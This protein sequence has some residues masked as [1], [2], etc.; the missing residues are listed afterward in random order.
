MP[1]LLAKNDKIRKEM[2][3]RQ[4]DTSFTYIFMKSPQEE[5]EHTFSPNNKLE[6]VADAQYINLMST[7]AYVNS[8]RHLKEKYITPEL[9]DFYGTNPQITGNIGYYDIYQAHGGDYNPKYGRL[10]NNFAGVEVHFVDGFDFDELLKNN[11]SATFLKEMYD[12]AGK[13]LNS[14]N[15]KTSVIYTPTKNIYNEGN[16][17]ERAVNPYVNFQQNNNVGVGTI[18]TE[19][20]DWK[21]TID[22][23]AS[24]FDDV[25]YQEEVNAPNIPTE[26]KYTNDNDLLSKTKELFRTGHIN[27]MIN[28]TQVTVNG[29]TYHKGRNFG[30]DDYGRAWTK[31]NEFLQVKNLTG[32]LKKKNGTGETVMTITEVQNEINKSFRPILYTENNKSYN[33]ADYLADNT[34]LNNSGFVNI[35]PSSVDSSKYSIKRCMF[36]IENLAWKDVAKV[37]NNL[38]EEQRGPNGGRIMWFPPY[39]LDFSENVSVD[40]DPNK[41]IGR[42]EEIFTYTNTRR[43]G[44]LSFSLLIDHPNIINV[45]GVR[46]EAE[47]ADFLKFFAGEGTLETSKQEED[48]KEDTHVPNIV[49]EETITEHEED[50][51]IAFSIYFPYNYSGMYSIRNKETY[52]NPSLNSNDVSDNDWFLYLLLGR[53]NGIKDWDGHSTIDTYW[54]GYEMTSGKGLTY[55]PAPDESD[56]PRIYIPNVM[57]EKGCT[58]EPWQV[59][60]EIDIDNDLYYCRSDFDIR[61]QLGQRRLARNSFDAYQCYKDDDSEQLNSFVEEENENTYPFASVLVA[62]LSANTYNDYVNVYLNYLQGSTIGIA[63]AP[64]QVSELIQKCFF[65]FFR[66]N[67]TKIEITPHV[68]AFEGVNEKN[69]SCQVANDLIG[70]RRGKTVQYFLANQLG[71]NLEKIKVNDYRLEY[72]N[73]DISDIKKSMKVDVVISYKTQ[74]TVKLSSLA[75]NVS[76]DENGVMMFQQNNEDYETPTGNTSDEQSGENK[77]EKQVVT[78]KRYETEAEYFSKLS[79]SDPFYF[80]NLKDK[81]RFFTPAFHSISPEGFNAR[82]NFL[83]QCTRQ[84]HTYEVNDSRYGKTAGNLAFGRMPVCVIRIGDFIYSKVIIE[85]MS[86]SYSDGGS[87]TWDLNKEGA[88]VQPMYAKVDLNII[89]L[90]GQSLNGPIS[91]LQNAVS[92]DYYANTG[93]YDDR[94]DIVQY[95]GNKAEYKKIWKPDE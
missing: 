86:I 67:I 21:R 88:G 94:A 90:G 42:G 84:G 51:T 33:G 72:T 78:Y 80:Q 35:T 17:T 31:K 58:F 81:F 40:W 10:P 87:M 32:N 83:Q 12:N 41:F 45:E 22:I 53:N 19:S 39:D 8:D 54:R 26:V 44:R 49:T 18:V 65:F 70:E 15:N 93:V 6:E 89:L 9:T 64:Q 36:S 47:D 66:K 5:Y 74:N 56:F 30:G 24:E 28:R 75:N 23:D 27:T 79:E 62:L 7:A 68:N 20:D 91:R 11:N 46:G 85:S 37:D 29:K 2:F 82:L 60:T 95:K 61:P 69:S 13:L 1:G 50:G 38:S 76:Y 59:G 52:E 25:D 92:F 4:R 14:Q 71:V 48:K 34:V 73:N 77:K 55:I 16:Y 43:N 63:D 57:D 3:L